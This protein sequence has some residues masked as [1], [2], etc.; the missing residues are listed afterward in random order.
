MIKLRAVVSLMD[1]VAVGRASS[2]I[3]AP[4]V[5]WNVS[6][7]LVSAVKLAFGINRSAHCWSLEEILS[8]R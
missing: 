7:S 4:V 2:L 5:S 1:T 8:L 3:A 6:E